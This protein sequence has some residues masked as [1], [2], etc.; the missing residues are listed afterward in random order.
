MLAVPRLLSFCLVLVG[1]AGSGGTP[2]TCEVMSPPSVMVPSDQ[3]RER[4]ESQSSGD[5]T[6][7][8][9]PVSCP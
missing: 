3:N 9:K 8:Q 4:V 6:P 7:D 1:C 5:P 2:S